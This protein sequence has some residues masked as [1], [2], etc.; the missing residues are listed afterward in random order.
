MRCEFGVA[1]TR[2]RRWLYAT[3]TMQ[4]ALKDADRIQGFKVL[5][6]LV[7]IAHWTELVGACVVTVLQ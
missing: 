1:T 6:P 2:A 4:V 5:S 3:F 7:G